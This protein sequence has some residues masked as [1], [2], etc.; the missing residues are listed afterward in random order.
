MEVKTTLESCP[1]TGR[2]MAAPRRTQC[3]QCPVLSPLLL[4]SVLLLA[5]LPDTRTVTQARLPRASLPVQNSTDTKVTSPFS[6]PFTTFPPHGLHCPQCRRETVL[7]KSF[8]EEGK[9]VLG[10]ET[11]Q[12]EGKEELLQGGVRCTF[13]KVS[14]VSFSTLLVSLRMIFAHDSLSS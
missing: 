6:P 5:G 1:R 10:G 3:C 9:Q 7:R 8:R 2:G 13:E 14:W 11:G 4:L 12:E